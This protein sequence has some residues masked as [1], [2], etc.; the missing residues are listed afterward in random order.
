MRL[1]LPGEIIGDLSAVADV[2]QRRVLNELIDQ[3]GFG[4]KCQAPL[5]ADDGLPCSY[6][7]I[8]GPDRLTACVNCGAPRPETKS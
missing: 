8:D 4:W 6:T 1:M 5:E 7:T 2:R 3:A